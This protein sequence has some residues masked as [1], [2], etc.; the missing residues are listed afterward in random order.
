MKRGWDHGGLAPWNEIVQKAMVGSNSR[1]HLAFR[2]ILYKL[3]K[4]HIL[5]AYLLLCTRQ[6]RPWRTQFYIL[7]TCWAELLRTGSQFTHRKK[8]HPDPVNEH[9]P[10]DSKRNALQDGFIYMWDCG[11]FV[12]ENMSLD[13]LR[14]PSS[15]ECNTAVKP[16]GWAGW[17]HL[18]PCCCVFIPVAASQ[19][20]EVQFCSRY[21]TMTSKN[22]SIFA[23]FFPTCHCSSSLSHLFCFR[24]ICFHRVGMK[25]MAFLDRKWAIRKRHLIICDLLNFSPTILLPPSPPPFFK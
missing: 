20:R 13:V 16:P 21:R 10:F 12:V 17:A 9:F 25:N 14:W 4:V 5:S 11:H 8:L 1:T 24:V 22:G 6:K 15:L 2:N 3:V 23:C 19:K 18:R 7:S